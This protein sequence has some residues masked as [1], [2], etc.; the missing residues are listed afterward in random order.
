MITSY[1][2]QPLDA[3]ETKLYI[4]HRLRLVGWQNDPYFTDEAY[5][6][7]FEAAGG[8][9]RKVNLLCDRLL[10]LG[11]LEEKHE[12][13]GEIVNEVVLDMHTEGSA[14]ALSA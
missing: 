14:P 9:P 10:L 3:E 7:I 5:Q 12:I 2:L 4:E 8:V 1:H 6:M 11:F 13:D